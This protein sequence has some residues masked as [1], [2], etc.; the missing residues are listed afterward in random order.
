LI[1]LLLFAASESFAVP[2]SSE[3]GWDPFG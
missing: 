1:G 3:N 2:I